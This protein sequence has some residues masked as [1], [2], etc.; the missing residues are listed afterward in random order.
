M[1]LQLKEISKSFFY[2]IKT[3]HNR[4]K[5]KKQ[6]I[7][8]TEKEQSGL[9]LIKPVRA[10]EIQDWNGGRALVFK[11]AWRSDEETSRG[12]ERKDEKFIGGEIRRRGGR[13][14][15]SPMPRGG[16]CASLQPAHSPP[17]QSGGA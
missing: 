11:Q 12:K 16:R 17:C 10:L 3:N 14:A 1:L 5:R 6:E 13:A 9:G 8:A 7:L 15:E 2:L 4:S